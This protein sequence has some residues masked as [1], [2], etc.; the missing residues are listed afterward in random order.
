MTNWK[1]VP[2][3]QGR[4]VLTRTYIDYVHR[5]NCQMGQQLQLKVTQKAGAKYGTDIHGF[6]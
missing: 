6:A 5:V 3:P 2:E 4:R 1:R